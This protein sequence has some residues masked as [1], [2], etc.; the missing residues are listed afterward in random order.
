MGSQLIPSGHQ[1]S[2][3][4]NSDHLSWVWARCWSLSSRVTPIL[5]LSPFLSRLLLE[6]HISYSSA[7]TLRHICPPY[8]D[9]S[10]SP[11]SMQPISS[12]TS[13]SDS[14]LLLV[15][16][17]CQLQVDELPWMYVYQHLLYFLDDY[18]YF[19]IWLKFY[20]YNL[21]RPKLY[22]GERSCNRQMVLQTFKSLSIWPMQRES[23]LPHTYPHFLLFLRIRRPAFRSLC[24][25]PARIRIYLPGK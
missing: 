14:V 3:R 6:N 25:I 4:R 20:V 22:S 23:I 15:A 11:T 7:G 18:D 5:Q 8:K 10:G 19:H 2:R 12:V 17:I 1:L 21:P 13:G 9:F 16:C 24:Y